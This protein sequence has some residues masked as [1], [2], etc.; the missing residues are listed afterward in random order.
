MTVDSK[1][2]DKDTKRVGLKIENG[3]VNRKEASVLRDTG[4][5]FILLTEKMIKEEDLTCGVR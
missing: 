3:E 4:C 1:K 5:T 2:V